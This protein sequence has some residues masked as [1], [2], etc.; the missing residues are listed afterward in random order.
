MRKTQRGF[1]LY[2]GKIDRRVIYL[3]LIIM[4][5]VPILWPI[6][7][8]LSVGEHVQA[9]YEFIDNAEPGSIIVL[10]WDV[11][12]ATK[13]EWYPQGTAIIYH[14]AQK[15]EL[16]LI[17]LAIRVDGAVFADEALRE[18]FDIPEN[19]STDEHPDYG[20]K[21]V[22]LGYVAGGEAAVMTMATELKGLVKFDHYGNSLESLDLAKNLV[23][24]KDTAFIIALSTG[25]HIWY[26]WKFL[27]VPYGTPLG[28]GGTA[29]I[30]AAV[31]PLYPND[32]VGYLGGIRGAAEYEYLVRRPGSAIAAMDAQLLAHLV[33]IFFVL[34]GNF[35]FL[36]RKWTKGKMSEDE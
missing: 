18:V 32:I 21:F 36:V 35:T 16:K 1:L 3:L 22:N 25:S 33:I 17:N 24:L 2:L 5:T 23:G 7:L 15:K 31:T 9:I 34:L 28:V 29:A 13:P 11:D 10:S 27:H 19:M 4:V 6:G 8:P 26:W 14:I 30:T 20:V 12:A